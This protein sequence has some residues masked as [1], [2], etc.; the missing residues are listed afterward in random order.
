MQMAAFKITLMLQN[1]IPN[2]R[3]MDIVNELADNYKTDDGGITANPH[4]WKFSDVCLNGMLLF[5]MCNNDIYQH[6]LII[7]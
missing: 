3:V 7:K 4:I 1:M 2:K 5:A 6:N